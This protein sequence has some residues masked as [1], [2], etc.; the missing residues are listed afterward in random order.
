[1]IAADAHSPL[2]R[3]R[4]K[5]EDTFGRF[6]LSQTPEPLIDLPEERLVKTLSDAIEKHRVVEIEYLKEGEDVPLTR[7]I[8]PYSFEREL[9]VWR[10]H[11]WD[12]TR[13][14]ARTYRL[15]RMREARLTTATFVPREGFD[16]LYLQ[17]TRVARVWHSP[18]IARWKVERGARPLT[19]KA[20]VRELTFG[21]EDWL[22]SEVFADRGETVVLEPAALRPAIAK[23]A[24]ALARELGVSRTRS[25]TRS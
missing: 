9:P 24:T 19:D 13:H 4:K 7:R 8:E 6:E 22:I 2:E 3:V 15:D 21:T 20:A 10:V 5:L 11:T 23:R 18:A 12:L 1:M 14:Q 17:D 25:R 16:P